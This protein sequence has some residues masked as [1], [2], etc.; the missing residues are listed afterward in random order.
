MRKI[1]GGVIV[2]G[3]PSRLVSCDFGKRDACVRHARDDIVLRLSAAPS[4]YHYPHNQ[5][6]LL[7]SIDPVMM[8]VI[9][10]YRQIGRQQQCR[11]K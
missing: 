5:Q 8:S 3:R 1:S 11:S 6:S 10:H 4:I 9:G 7:L 2:K